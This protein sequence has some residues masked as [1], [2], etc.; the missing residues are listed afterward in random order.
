MYPGTTKNRKIKT[1]GHSGGGYNGSLF[2][3][4]ISSNNSVERRERM[5][6]TM[7]RLSSGLPSVVLKGRGT[8]YGNRSKFNSKLP[9]D[10]KT[11]N[12][13]VNTRG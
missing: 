8:G 6:E 9:I 2:S 1:P 13:K 12:R 4:P 7:N 3:N 10:Y 11:S 5:Q